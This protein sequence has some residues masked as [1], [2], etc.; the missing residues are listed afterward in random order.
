MDQNGLLVDELPDPLSASSAG[1]NPERWLEGVPAPAK[2]PQTEQLPPAFESL[3][4]N[5]ED[6]SAKERV[7]SEENM[8]FP[9]SIKSERAKPETGPSSNPSSPVMDDT[10]RP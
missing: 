4:L 9:Q 2:S 10:K 6:T 3:S 7:T 1:V 5:S 8:K